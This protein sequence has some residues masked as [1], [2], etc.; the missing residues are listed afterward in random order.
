MQPESDAED[1]LEGISNPRA[2]L[3]VNNAK[4]V[5]M[6]SEMYLGRK[7]IVFLGNFEGFD[8]LTDLWINDNEITSIT[9]L[10]NCV[11]I[12]RLYA[13]NNRIRN[14]YGSLQFMKFIEVLNL[15]NNNIK[16]LSTVLQQLSI[17]RS[18]SQLDLS[19]NP[20]AEETAYRMQVIDKLPQV[21]V[22]DCSKVKSVERKKARA[23]IERKKRRALKGN[24]RPNATKTK[25]KAKPNPYV[26]TM[27]AT[28]LMAEEAMARLERT[29]KRKNDLERLG[30]FHARAES[31][32]MEIPASLLSDRASQRDTNLPA[33]ALS[34][35]RVLP[36]ML[37]LFR[38]YDTNGNGKL[39]ADELRALVADMVSEGY[40]LHSAHEQSQLETLLAALD[41]NKDGQISWKE[42]EDG[43]QGELRRATDSLGRPIGGSSSSV[44][45]LL[46]RAVDRDKASD[47]AQQ[48]FALLK[49]LR[50]KAELMDPENEAAVQMH[51]RML[52]LSAKA[53]RFSMLAQTPAMKTKV[54]TRLNPY[55]F[56][57]LK[58]SYKKHLPA[59]RATRHSKCCKI[60]AFIKSI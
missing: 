37:E 44:R 55:V 36:A 1:S 7:G 16:D 4:Y 28:A 49:G 11:R 41:T 29:A 21:Q 42:F 57:G 50:E 51:Q 19:G 8:N 46:W 58:S 15:A 10:D 54:K 9:D 27:S 39:S 35:Q 31:Q 18:L 25:S 5:R 2:E 52:A 48:S 33:G 38:K 43:L 22:L 17:F 59:A 34:T 20:V 30:K 45:P 6:C 26:D 60:N 56:R 53:N 32:R 40:T 23:Y 14:L 13:H 12:R 3:P 24:I 47:L